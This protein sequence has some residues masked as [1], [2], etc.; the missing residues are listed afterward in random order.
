MRREKMEGGETGKG[1]WRSGRLCLKIDS[2]PKFRTLPKIE[3]HDKF[4]ARTS[5]LAVF[6]SAEPTHTRLHPERITHMNFIYTA[7]VVATLVFSSLLMAGD[8]EREAYNKSPCFEEDVYACHAS[9]G[10]FN[11]S[12]CMCY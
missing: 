8:S 5:T 10:T 11:W 1:G 6:Y 4:A 2:C 12:H 3:G 9:G 7:V